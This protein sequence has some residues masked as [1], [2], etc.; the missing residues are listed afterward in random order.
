MKDGEGSICY[1]FVIYSYFYFINKCKII[2]L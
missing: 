1:G 2:L